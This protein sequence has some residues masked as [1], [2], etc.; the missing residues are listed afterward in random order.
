[1]KYVKK[2]LAGF[3]ALLL[4][5]L[6]LAM[7]IQA[8]EENVAY[9]ADAF[10]GFPIGQ[11]DLSAGEERAIR[12]KAEVPAGK[13]LKAYSLSVTYDDTKVVVES[14][15]VPAEAVFPPMNINLNKA[16][17]IFINGFDVNGFEGPN[18]FS[19]LDA[20]VKGLKPGSFDLVVS[21][22]G[23]GASEGEQF[24]PAI[25]PVQITVK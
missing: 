9:W 8:N 10:S 12:L 2:Y 5:V 18:V 17:I 15:V 3:L 4:V 14:V 16:G 13:T 7:P 1:M 11:L 20:V 23:F 19:F 6:A 22:K 21:F 24:V 25:A